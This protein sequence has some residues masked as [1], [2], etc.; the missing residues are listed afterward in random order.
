MKLLVCDWF[1]V[2]K[3]ASHIWFDITSS[4]K[5]VPKALAHV[6]HLVEVSPCGAKFVGFIPSQGTFLGCGFDVRLGHV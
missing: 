3:N 2:F 5:Y 1:L 6:A 4:Q